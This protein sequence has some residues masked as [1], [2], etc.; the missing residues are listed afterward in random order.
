MAIAEILCIGTELLLGQVLNT[1]AHYLSEQLAELGINCYHHTVVGDN[2]DRMKEAL[3]LA[4]GRVDVVL[5][6]GGLGPT[7]DDLTHEMLAD[8]FG[9]D[10]QLDEDV[11]SRIQLFFDQRGV[12]MPESNKKQAYRPLGAERMNNPRGTAPGVCWTLTQP[13][14]SAKGIPHPERERVVL[15]FPGVPSEMKGLWMDI[16]RPFL[17]KKYG[18]GIVWSCE[19][20]HYGIGESLLAEKY[21]HLLELSN[22]TVAPY[23]GLGECRLR[24]TAR[25]ATEAEA[26][27]LA[28]PVLDEIKGESK[29]LCY[30]ENQETL[31]S[32]VGKL[33]TAARLTISCA[34]SCTG[35]LVSKRLT[36][37][38]GSSRYVSLNVVT[39]SNEAKQELLKVPKAVL[40]E[41][42]A[43]SQECAKAMSEGV[44]LMSGSDI[45]LA[46]TG[47]AGPDGG[48]E[49]K[50]VG[51]VYIGI[52]TDEF[53]AVRRYNY[54]RHLSRQDIRQRTSSD[55]LNLVRQYL[56]DP[57]AVF[58]SKVKSEAEG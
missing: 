16:A 51:L 15:T 49:D 22:P 11:L 47:I 36:D 13:L 5:I 53:T 40:D 26:I 30:G 23:A 55:A 57:E 41:F 6:T 19:L 10:M 45:G 32:V 7:P 12:P 1:N 25:A 4:L 43:V 21:N 18:P 37:V 9:V 3:R 29:F 44:Q 33:L 8:F 56:L 54:P 35:G 42:G 58:P 27:A 39:Y 14:L 52:S 28:K 17:Q 38:P 48:S 31:E 24:V 20:K 50:P 2:V 34:E 46:V